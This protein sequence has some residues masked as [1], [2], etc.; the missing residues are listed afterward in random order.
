MAIGLKSAVWNFNGWRNNMFPKWDGD[1]LLFFQRMTEHPLL[2]KF[3]VFYTSLGNKGYL[4]I[5]IGII[6]IIFKKTRKTGILLLI[7]LLISHLLNN[8]VLKILIDRPRPYE[9]IP[10]VR[11]LIGKVEET[12]FP[13]GH[14]AIA[15][16]S[17]FVIF[18]REKGWLRW[19][20]LVMAILMALSRLYVGVHYP[21]DVLAGSI[22]GMLIASGVIFSEKNISRKIK[23]KLN[24]ER[25]RKN[26]K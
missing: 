5:A 13:S 26:S 17:A 18:L 24:Q 2:D 16:G 1:L 15:F 10:N 12:S 20:A 4:W 21:T 3:F 11:M 8:F 7:S 9:V 6:L 23:P 22:V 25:N 14:S 19:T